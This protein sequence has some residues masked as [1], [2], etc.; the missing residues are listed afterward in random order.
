MQDYEEMETC[1]Y[2]LNAE[3]KKELNKINLIFD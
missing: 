3:N 2:I 1:Y